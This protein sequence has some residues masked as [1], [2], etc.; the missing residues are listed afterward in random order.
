M[1]A[2][3]RLRFTVIFTVILTGHG[4]SGL[5]HGRRRPRRS[6][7][8]HRFRAAGENDTAHAEHT[9]LIL[10]HVPGVDLAVDAALP[11][12]SRDELRVLRPEVEDQDPVGVN[13]GWAD[14][15]RLS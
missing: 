11:H 7:V 2:S 9:D 8:D 15:G 12:A 3:Q 13:V 4:S 10:T 5:E 6:R 14:G 1:L